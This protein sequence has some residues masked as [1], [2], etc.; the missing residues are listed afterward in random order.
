MWNLLSCS[1]IDLE[2]QKIYTLWALRMSPNISLRTRYLLLLIS[3][4]LRQGLP[5]KTPNSN[6]WACKTRD[7]YSHNHTYNQLTIFELRR[8]CGRFYFDEI[9]VFWQNI[10]TN[11][12]ICNHKTYTK[13]PPSPRPKTYFPSYTTKFPRKQQHAQTVGVWETAV[14][15][16]RY[17][18]VSLFHGAVYALPDYSR[19]HPAILLSWPPP[20]FRPDRTLV[21]RLSS[22]S[23]AP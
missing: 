12:R 15:V 16:H 20:P 21:F 10:L 23:R 19:R 7:L 6:F 2:P 4:F 22:S 3:S 13:R 17:W 18:I 1:S 5:K 14:D 11:G 9:N 8:I